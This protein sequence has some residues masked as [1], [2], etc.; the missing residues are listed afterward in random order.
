VQWPRV[1]HIALTALE[2]PSTRPRGQNIRRP[3][4]FGSGS[5]RNHQ[6]RR[7]LRISASIPNGIR[8]KKLSSGGPASSMHTRTSGSSLS[9]AAS[10]QPAEPSPT[11]T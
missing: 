6:L 10:T 8:T 11:M 9:R 5:V 7:R 2:P 4:Q 3:A 1:Q